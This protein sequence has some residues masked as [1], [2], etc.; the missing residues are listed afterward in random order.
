MI[1]C[2]LNRVVMG[3]LLVPLVLAGGRSWSQVTTRTIAHEPDLA[4]GRTE[5][6]DRI[7]FSDGTMVEGR[8]LED[9]PEEVRIE[10]KRGTF[11]FQRVDVRRIERAAA[12]SSSNG[13]AAMTPFFDVHRTLPTGALNPAKPPQIPP[14]YR[15]AVNA[16]PRRASSVPTRPPAGQALT[17]VP[18]VVPP[19][20]AAAAGPTSKF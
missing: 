16:L 11:T 4:A 3:Y 17:P 8:I 12:K 19:N 14:V 20:P 15:F 6:M 18:T 1:G 10:T 7:F 13:G 5:G 9:R 2:A